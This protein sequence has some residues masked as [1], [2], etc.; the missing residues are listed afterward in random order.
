MPRFSYRA[1]DAEGH[2]SDGIV[3]GETE[4]DAIE[5]LRDR[6]LVPLRVAPAEPGAAQ[7]GVRSAFRRRRPRPVD[8][9]VSLRQ[10]ALMLRS[11]VTLL[12]ALRLAAEHAG[13]PALEELWRA[14]SARVRSGA[15]FSE[16]L[17]ESDAVPTVAVAMTSVGERTGDLDDALDRAAAAM[18]RRRLLLTSVRTALLYPAIV[19]VL[20][21]GV[22]AYMLVGLVPKVRSFLAGFGRTLPPLTQALVDASEFVERHWMTGL[23]LAAAALAAL[24][25]V[26]ASPPGRLATDRAALRVPIAGHTVRLAATAG[27]AR[28]LS[29]LLASGVRLTEALLVLERLHSNRW[30]A[31]RVAAARARVVD[32]SALAPALAAQGGFLP[33]LSGMAAIGESSGALDTVL[34]RTAA[35]HEARLESHVKRLGSLIEP[36]IVIVVGGIVGFV[37]LACFMAIY[38]VAGRS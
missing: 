18:E 21:I 9:E 37:Y 4:R 27:A 1:V 29:T 33:L 5:R 8:L 10:I 2:R 28:T 22:V 7:A 16:A 13:S 3:D 34:D 14:A 31:S 25:L 6:Q 32:G 11:G 23:V 19:V 15:S 36:A 12:D 38:A 24:W 20:A 35:F 26:R 17:S 30:L